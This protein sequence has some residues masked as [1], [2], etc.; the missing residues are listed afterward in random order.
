MAN[1]TSILGTD[2][3]SASRST[4]NTNFDNLN[5]SKVETSVLTGG[6]VPK[7]ITAS[8]LG[9]GMADNTTFLRGDLTWN[10]IPNPSRTSLVAYQ[11]NSSVASATITMNLDPVG[12]VYKILNKIDHS[13]SENKAYYQI[14]GWP[15]NYNQA[16]SYNEFTAGN[17]QGVETVTSNIGVLSHTALKGHVTEADLYTVFNAAYLSGTT[18]STRSATNSFHRGIISFSGSNTDNLFSSITSLTFG[19][20]VGTASIQTWIYQVL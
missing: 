19:V 8:V 9:T 5:T 15:Q 7:P 14:N 16:I 1:L 17:T 12:N 6:Y 11:S 10:A 3:V 20:S 18:Y 13:S 4:I 2:Q